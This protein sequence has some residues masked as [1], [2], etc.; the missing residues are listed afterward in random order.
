M[1]PRAVETPRVVDRRASSDPQER[2]KTLPQSLTVDPLALR[3]ATLEE[4]EDTNR[5]LDRRNRE[6]EDFACI[7]AHEL[8]APLRGLVTLTQWR[9]AE[10]DAASTSSSPREHLALL[11]GRI[12]KMEA[13]VDGILGYARA[14]QASDAVS[15]LDVGGLLRD[16]LEL[17]GAPNGVVSFGTAMPRLVTTRVPLQQTFMNLI[18]NALQHGRR[19]GAHVSIGAEQHGSEWEFYVTDNGPGI[20]PRHHERIFALFY[21]LS[22]D[23]SV[24]TGIGLSVV[25]K[26]VDGVG[27][28]VWVESRPGEGATFRF[29]WPSWRGAIAREP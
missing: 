27:G 10:G 24:G 13:L 19:V 17:L 29:R 8:K 20:A 18:G 14:G 4:L 21:T 6:L 26:I 15:E 11:R 5:L 3:R 9:E 7:A 22:G 28:R 25:K 1:P 2:A 23:P 12:L 16:T